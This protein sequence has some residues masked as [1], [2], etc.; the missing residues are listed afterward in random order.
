SVENLS[1]SPV[2]SYKEIEAKIEEGTK[3]RTIAA[4]NMNATSSSERQRDAG[5]EGDRMKEGIVINQSL[6]T[7]GRVIKAL[8]EQ[9]GSKGKKVQIP[10]RDSVLT[11]LLKNALG[12]NS[13][14]IMV[15]CCDLTC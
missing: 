15:D 14:T 6:S 2:N 12:G 1:S 9:Q 4:T 3:N 10:Y 8:H 13:K 11:C 5:T 7:L